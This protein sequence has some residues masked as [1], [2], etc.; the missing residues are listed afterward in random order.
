MQFWMPHV[1][2]VDTLHTGPGSEI[3]SL[4]P[5]QVC[6]AFCTVLASVLARMPSATM[7]SKFGIASAVL[8][9]VL[10][11]HREDVRALDVRV[12]QAL[13]SERD[14]RIY[15]HSFPGPLAC[16]VRRF[17]YLCR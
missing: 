1:P 9:T 8:C 11:R 13:E 15:G 3:P 12:H 5:W 16:L 17:S 10:E 6:T 7:R 4:L 2:S 14:L